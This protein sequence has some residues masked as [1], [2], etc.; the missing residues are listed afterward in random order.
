MPHLTLHE[1]VPRVDRF[2]R[3]SLE[4]CGGGCPSKATA[5]PTPKDV[6]KL[7]GVWG[8]PPK[9]V[10]RL[11]GVWGPP[12]KDVYRV[13]GVWGPPPKDVYRLPGV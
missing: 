9:D 10:Y 8:P 12:P 7:L 13:L 5:P 11:L 2:M 4:G 1:H 6:Y 3:R